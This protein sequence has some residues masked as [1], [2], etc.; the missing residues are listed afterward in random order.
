LS[1]VFGCPFRRRNFPIFFGFV[2]NLEMMNLDHWPSPFVDFPDYTGSMTKVQRL[3]GN[4][5]RA[6]D[7]DTSIFIHV[8]FPT[9]AGFK[10]KWSSLH[11]VP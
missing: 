2:P 11:L 1:D 5:C 4:C 10:T 7:A 3:P 6:R 8:S 9:I